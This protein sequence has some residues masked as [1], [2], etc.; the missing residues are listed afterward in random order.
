MQAIVNP[1]NFHPRTARLEFASGATSLV[2][3]SGDDKDALASAE[4][5]PPLGGGIHVLAED[6]HD[7]WKRDR[8]KQLDRTCASP[9]VREFNAHRICPRPEEASSWNAGHVLGHG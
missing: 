2:L 1:L 4:C 3:R 5:A 6:C 7:H 8:A 9:R